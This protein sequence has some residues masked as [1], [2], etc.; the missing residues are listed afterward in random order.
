VI[1]YVPASRTQAERS[2]EPTA[3]VAERLAAVKDADP[4]TTGAAVKPA[5]AEPPPAAAPSE[6]PKVRRA[7]A[8]NSQQRREGDWN[9]TGNYGASRYEYG[10]GRYDYGRSRYAE[11]PWS[12]GSRRWW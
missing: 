5:A 4:E 3:T 7:V 9:W 8:K 12:S 2:L 10:T 6:R 11:Q 1:N